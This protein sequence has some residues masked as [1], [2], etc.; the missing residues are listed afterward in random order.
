MPLLAWAHL[1]TNDLP[2]AE[3]LAELAMERATA[4][5]MRLYLVDAL[6]VKGMVQRDG[7]HLQEAERTF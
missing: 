7:R 2:R 3:P 1:E 5:G 4:T 6:P